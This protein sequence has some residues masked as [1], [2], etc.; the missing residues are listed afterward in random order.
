MSCLQCC[1]GFVEFGLKHQRLNQFGDDRCV[2]WVSLLQLCEVCNGLRDGCL[3]ITREQA[4][5][6]PACLGPGSEVEIL[7][8]A[9]HFLLV[10]RPERVNPRILG[11]LAQG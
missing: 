2:L 4:T 6:I 1:E 10:E 7:D 5:R 11:F 3:A 8:D 9:G